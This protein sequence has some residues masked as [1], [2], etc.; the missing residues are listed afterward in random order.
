[1][2]IWMVRG[3]LNGGISACGLSIDTYVHVIVVSMYRNV[4]IIYCVVFFVDILN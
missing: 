2:L 3:K 1:M 4:Q